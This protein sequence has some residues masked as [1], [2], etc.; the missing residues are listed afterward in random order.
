[1][2]FTDILPHVGWQDVQEW[3]TYNPKKPLLFNTGLFLGLFIVFYGIYLLLR[4]TFHLR[5]LYVVCFSVFF[6]YK[7]SGMY[8]LLLLFTTIVDYTLSYFLYRETRELQRKLYVWFSVIINLTFLGYFKYTNFLIG[9]Y[10]DLFGGKFSFYDVILPV[11]ISFYT[12]QS[13]SYTIE[14]YRKEITP[15]KNYLDYLFF[16]SFFPQLV[17]GPIVRAKDFIPK[18]YEKLSITKQDVN[19]GLFLIIGGLIKKTVISDYISVN[20]V[21]RVFDSP[22]SYTAFENLMASYGYTIQIY[23]DFSGYSDMAIGIA[24]LLGF[25]LPPNFHTPYKSASI[26]EFWRRW[27]ISLSTW[28][29]DFLYIS[30]GG[31]RH[32]SFAGF[33]FPALFFFGLIVWGI[34]YSGTSNW[35]LIIGV[36]ALLVFILTFMLSKN[37]EKTMYTNSNLLTTMLL[38]G[39]WHGASLRFIVWGALHGIALAVH[40]I[41]MEFFP[42]KKDA[43]KTAA[44]A[45]WHFVSV[46]L[47]FHFVAFCWIFFRAKDFP[48]AMDVLDNITKV[49]FN[50]QQWQT[51]IMGYK[52]VFMLMFAGYVWH[53]LPESIINAMR[54]AFNR[55]PLAGKAVL[56]GFVYWLVYAA[57]SAGPQPFIYFQF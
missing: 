35:P 19:Y 14:I 1:M 43:K 46:V 52:N 10:N 45:L 24:L 30:V 5:I 55:T 15:A 33:L 7:S 23:C 2:Q 22:N 4:K 37:K 51:I 26:T 40:K 34:Q 57:A 28:L 20:F 18:I 49:T 3:F 27:H 54:Q 31:N 8:F 47:T 44:G 38:G 11:G 9:N 25:E 42:P 6:Y 56:L 16:V 13:I 41:F 53:F 50:P 17:A 32:G 36:S 21:D 12:F 39:L 48:T 29:K